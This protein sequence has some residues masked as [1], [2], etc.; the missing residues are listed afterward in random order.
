MPFATRWL[1]GDEAG[2][3]YLDFL[4]TRF[5]AAAATALD[6]LQPI[7]WRHG[8]IRAPGLNRNRRPIYRTSDGEYVGT[9]GAADVAEF[10]RYE[11]PVDDELQVLAAETSDGE[12]IG[13]LLNFPCHPV[14]MY[15]VPVWSADFIGPLTERLQEQSGGIFLFLNG[16]AGNIAP[17]RK[18]IPGADAEAQAKSN[19][20]RIGE[21][22]AEKA[23]E[24]LKSGPL[25]GSDGIRVTREILEIPQRRPSARQVELA[26]WFLQEAKPRSSVNIEDFCRKL[27]GYPFTMFKTNLRF[28]TWMC[29]EIIG[30]FE[31]QRRA[32]GRELYDHVEIFGLALGEAAL[33]SFPAEVFV[34]LGLAV[35]EQSP[36]PANMVIEQANGW[37]GYVPMEHCFARGG[38]ETSLAYQ[39]KLVPEAAQLMQDA[40]L[41]VLRSLSKTR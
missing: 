27:Y 2:F 14:T 13:G 34:E 40:A 31:W 16:A 4:K 23:L 38:Y 39:S 41:R 32:A 17:V 35:K 22:L 24:A 21:T 10:L 1:P 18:E 20:R 5:A 25:L 26:Q 8:R 12:T 36:F 29:G 37:H 11:G 6:R 33:V 15:A 7:R 19:A 3:A 30:M 28:L 9:N